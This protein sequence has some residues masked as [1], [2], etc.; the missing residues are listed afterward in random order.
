MVKLKIPRDIVAGYEPDSRSVSTLLPA[1]ERKERSARGGDRGRGG[2]SS[3]STA[4]QGFIDPIFQEPYTPN[5]APVSPESTG[6]QAK[7]TTTVRPQ[8]P[9]A[10]LLGGLIKKA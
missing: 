4:R 3:G 10:A 9:V 7:Q 8:R 2:R 5:Q 1:P 6:S